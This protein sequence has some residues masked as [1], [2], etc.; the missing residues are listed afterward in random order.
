MVTVKS[1]DQH[2]I[3]ISQSFLY[4]KQRMAYGN[5]SFYLQMRLFYCILKLSE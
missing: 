2:M 1:V 3:I 5:G 4:K